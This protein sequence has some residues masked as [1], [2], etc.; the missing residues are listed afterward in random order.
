M[1]DALDWVREHVF[2]REYE[3]AEEELNHLLELLHRLR[4]GEDPLSFIEED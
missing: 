1:S 2:D 3:S 4:E